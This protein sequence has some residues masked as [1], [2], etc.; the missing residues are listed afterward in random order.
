MPKFQFVECV[1]GART[2][3][4]RAPN[5]EAAHALY[6]K[7][8]ATDKTRDC[9]V[10]GTKVW[11]S[12]LTEVLDETGKLLEDHNPPAEELEDVRRSNQ[13]QSDVERGY[14]GDVRADADNEAIAEVPAA[15]SDDASTGGPTAVH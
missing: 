9:R 7:N 13:E 6:E 14:D 4:V 10:V 12:F 2:I 5:L 3:E 11:D 8:G 1:F 15:A